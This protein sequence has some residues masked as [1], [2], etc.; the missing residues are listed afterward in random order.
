M[1]VKICGLT[2]LEALDAALQSGADAVGFVFAASVRQL[3][4]AQAAMLAR[5]ARG[6]AALIAVTLHPTQQQIDE[7]IR[8]FQP[9]VLQSD[10]SDFEH[11]SLPQTLTRLPV[12]RAQPG[13]ASD[14]AHSRYP[15]RL[16][17]EGA[18]SGS[19]EVSD[20]Q[21]AAQWAKVRELVLAGGLHADNVAGAI[22]AVHPFGVD[23][24]SGVEDAPGRKS[25]AKIAQFIAGARSALKESH[26]NRSIG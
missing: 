16:L 7:I 15:S 20:W 24:S 5:A 10:F 14:H 1:W 9:D 4:P 18:R 11:L 2:T 25:P 23:V 6:K 12:I 17:F 8:V 26:G 13:A 3:L 19:G 22:A 21:A